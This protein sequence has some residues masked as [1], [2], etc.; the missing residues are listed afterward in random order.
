MTRERRRTKRC[1][2]GVI[3]E[4]E[5]IFCT[6]SPKLKLPTIVNGSLPSK[7][8]KRGDGGGGW[9]L[10][11]L[12]S[13]WSIW[14]SRTM[15]KSSGSLTVSLPPLSLYLSLYLSIS[16]SPLEFAA[17]YG[18]ASAHILRAMSTQK[19]GQEGRKEGLNFLELDF[20]FY[21]GD[22]LLHAER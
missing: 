5:V 21:V 1:I 2:Y 20:D 4:R 18:F 6:R 14:S 3:M 7:R 16:L 15:S 11:G 19:F 17:A 10:V 13:R 8:K 22:F 12:A 9:W